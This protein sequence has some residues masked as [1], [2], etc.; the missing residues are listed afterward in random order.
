MAGPDR[1]LRGFRPAYA[2]DRDAAWNR[3]LHGPL[4]PGLPGRRANR[5]ALALATLRYVPDFFDILP[6]YIVLLAAAPAM[7]ILAG[8]SGRLALGVSGALWLLVQVWPLNL[9]A[10]PVSD[11]QWYFDPL[12]WQFLFFIGFGATAGWFRPPAPSRGRIALAAAVI[13]ACIPLTFWAAHQVWPALGDLYR[14]IYPHDA[15]STLHPL[16]L[17]HAL[18]LGWLFAA[19]LA[20]RRSSLAESNVLKPVLVVGQQSLS[21][22]IAGIFLSALAGVALDLAGRDALTTAAV[23]LG[24]MA[25]I[26]LVAYA[27][28]AAKSASRRP[29]PGTEEIPCLAQR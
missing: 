28:R 6:L 19:L 3:R 22:F 26:V 9:P 1:R 7:V 17:A 15:I 11:R 2:V 24:G 23:N 14:A 10:S 13:L 27:A 18:I 16:R 8:A 29:H 5:A 12:A 4:Q 25:S 20:E 21:A